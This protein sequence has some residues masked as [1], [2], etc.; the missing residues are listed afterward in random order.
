MLHVGYP[1]CRIDNCS[2]I[3]PGR[4]G[5]TFADLEV[6]GHVGASHR[7]DEIGNFIG[8]HI[9]VDQGSFWRCPVH[10]IQD[11]GQHFIF[12]FNQVQRFFGNFFAGSGHGCHS[13]TDKAHAFAGKGVFIAD[14]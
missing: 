12:Y 11:W 4:F 5:I 6:I 2:A 10:R 7:E 13:F 9:R 3:L 8:G 1:D 14:V